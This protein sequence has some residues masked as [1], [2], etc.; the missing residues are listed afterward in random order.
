MFDN[1][2]GMALP[3][4][5]IL[6]VVASTLV[7]PGLW[8]TDNMLFVNQ[9]L[10]NR[11]MAY[12]AAKSGIENAYWRLRNPDQASTLN[13]N[14][15]TINGM[16]VRVTDVPSGN[17][18]LTVH[19]FKSEGIDTNGKTLS[20]VYA[21]MGVES[22]AGYPFKYAIGSTDGNIVIEPNSQ[23]NFTPKPNP[24]G[25]M[26]DMWA[27]GSI[28]V[29]GTTANTKVDGTAY[30]TSGS[31][32]NCALFTTSPCGN[33]SST[34]YEFQAIDILWYWDEAIKSGTTQWPSG[35]TPWPP[36]LVPPAPLFNSGSTWNLPSGTTVLGGAG[37]VSYIK[38]NLN[39]NSR[40]VLLK[41]MVWVDGY[42][43]DQN[44]RINTDP[45]RPLEQYYLF[46]RGYNASNV[47]ISLKNTVINA[48]GNLNLV[49][50][51]G[52]VIVDKVAGVSGAAPLLG[53]VY[54][55][56]GAVTLS[57]NQAG[58][59]P[60]IG[61]VIGKSVTLNSNVDIWYNT[62]LRNNPIGGT[63]LNTVN[64]AVMEYSAQ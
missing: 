36:L 54:A 1:Q 42:I 35:Q 49:A 4:A 40:T 62:A 47:G 55:P 12:Y 24:D 19:N 50:D 29:N 6:L 21:S 31:A 20:T 28:T 41:G 64:V 2:S 63:K 60:K 32:P 27:N 11:A 48:N 56:N 44:G 57:G 26:A 58:E 51:N 43:I 22:V 13:L 5:L 39:I 16:T 38:G 10:T 14:G 7:M 15:A 46:A 3:M 59:R 52:G 9:D 23:V 33:Y 18:T 17:S 8:A 53:I 61:A 30:Y 45:T 34:P 25:I 37:N